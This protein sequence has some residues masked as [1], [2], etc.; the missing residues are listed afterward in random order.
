MKAGSSPAVAFRAAKPVTPSLISRT[1]RQGGKWVT[2]SVSC[3]S[4]IVTK[5]VSFAASP[6]C[7]GD[8][9][10]VTGVDAV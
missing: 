8:T 7:G 6:L 9:A 5:N 10:R 3:Q 1:R 4:S 2:R